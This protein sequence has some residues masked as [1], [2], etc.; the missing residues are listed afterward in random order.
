MTVTETRQ[1]GAPVRRFRCLSLLS[2]S[3][4][5]ALRIQTT[6]AAGVGPTAPRRAPRPLRVLPPTAGSPTTRGPP[7]APPGSDARRATT[8]AARAEA[9]R[10]LRPAR[11]PAR[12]AAA[13]AGA[14]T[15]GRIVTR[16]ARPA[17][18]S[19][20][21]RRGSLVGIGTEARGARPAHRRRPLHAR[22]IPTGARTLAI[23]QGRTPRRGP[24][25]SLQ[26]RPLSPPR[27]L[28][29]PPQPPR[30][31][32]RRR[33]PPQPRTRPTRRRGHRALILRRGLRRAQRR[34]PART[35]TCGSLTRLPRPPVPAAPR[36]RRRRLRR[37]G[38]LHRLRRPP[39]LARAPPP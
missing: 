25:S 11:R 30:P 37:R 16:P 36:T 3:P 1:I 2:P 31:R 33:R 6:P 29:R 38:S 9:A 19:V 17:A 34:A 28:P 15:R 7:T 5:T 35:R 13:T 22:R 12:V 4:R 10:R 18:S 23:P 39:Q 26:Q 24:L 27:G 8:R 14:P 32:G 21:I 20:T